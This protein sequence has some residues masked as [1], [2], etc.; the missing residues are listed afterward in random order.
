MRPNHLGILSVLA[1]AMVFATPAVYAQNRVV[2]NVVFDFHLGQKAMSSGQYE[3]HSMSQEVAVL[4]DMD[5]NISA[6]LIKSMHVQGT[7]N[8]HARLVFNKYGD[9]YFLSQIWDGSETGIELP[10][11]QREK[12]ISMARDAHVPETVI[13]A[14]K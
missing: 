6:F 11:S 1:L 14:M 4:R 12:E 7:D 5:S 10:K 13:V 2:A 8:E 9:Q 3:V